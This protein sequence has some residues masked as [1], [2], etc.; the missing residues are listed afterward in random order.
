MSMKLMFITNEPEIAMIAQS[1]GVDRI[2]IDLERIGKL[3]RQGHLD[4]VI[5]THSIEDVSLLRGVINSSELLVRINPIHANSSNEI[6]SVIARKADILM[7]PM[8][9]TTQEVTAF[10]NYV[11]GRAKTCLLLETKEALE[12]ID[13][14]LEIDGI[15]EI[16]IGLN[17]LHLSLGL[18]FMFE[19]LSNGIIDDVCEKIKA[20]GITFGFGGIARL[21]Q[22]TL[23]AEHIITEH[24]RLGSQM[25]ILS[26]SFCNVKK[27]GSVEEIKR[28]IFHGVKEIR[29]FER[30][31]NIYDYQM[32]E[33]NKQQVKNIVDNETTKFV[34]S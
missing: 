21:G 29:E 32:F 6:E 27:I 30:K 7:L 23:P 17:D 20:K 31:L 11:N 14:I 1:A 2:F 24:Y 28:T 26:R 4:T 33:R 12:R 5:S 15:D 18:N 19:L 8:F 34:K 13:D 3:E 9:K 10:I 25:V 16:H 22:G